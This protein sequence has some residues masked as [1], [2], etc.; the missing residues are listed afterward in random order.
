MRDFYS[1]LYG[2]VAYQVSLALVYF[3]SPTWFIAL[4]NKTIY[5]GLLASEEH[6]LYKVV[7]SFDGYLAEFSNAVRAL[8][9]EVESA[10]TAA[11]RP[12]PESPHDSYLCS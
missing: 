9:E 1:L 4:L 2:A 8:L 7:H 6:V 11:N 10:G 12:L 5:T 3:M